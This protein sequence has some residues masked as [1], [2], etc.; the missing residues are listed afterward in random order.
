MHT[1]IGRGHSD[2]RPAA[3]R[4]THI[5]MWLRTVGCLITLALG[6]SVALPQGKIPTVGVLEPGRQQQPPPWT[7]HGGFRQGLRDLGYVEGQN[8]VLEYRYA[9]GQPDRLPDLA[10]ELVRLTPKVLWTY[11]EL[12]VRATKQATTTI[13]IVVGVSSDLVEQ[14]LVK[15]LA[16]PGGNLTGLDLREIELMGKRLELL[17]EAVPTISHVAVLVNPAN[18]LHS[19]VPENIAAE[20]RA[21]GVQLQ[22]VE[23]G[24]PEAFEGAFAAM[25]Q[26]GADALMIPESPFFATHRRQILELALRHRLPTMCSGRHFAEAGSLGAYG[27]FPRDLCKR[28]AVLV[29]KILKGA[30]PADLPVERGDKFYLIVNLKTADTMGLTLSPW[31]LSQVDEVIR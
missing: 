26:R 1:T 4:G 8:I 14:G 21:L 10:A 5:T 22:R 7:C 2:Q 11:S 9:E 17:K 18:R 28:S 23:T 19:G 6:S 12:A 3:N 16:R 29:D 20:A 25:V 31:F 27:A 15:S 24:A 13:P 30:K